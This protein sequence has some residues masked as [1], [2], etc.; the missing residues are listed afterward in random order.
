M[1]KILLFILLLVSYILLSAQEKQHEIDLSFGVAGG[2]SGRLPFWLVSNQYSLLEENSFNI[3]SAIELQKKLNTNKKF[4][5][6]YGAKLINRY[7]LNYQIYPEEIFA[8]I[9]YEP[10]RFQIGR[11]R[12]IFSNEDINLSSGGLLWSGN[13]LPLPAM[14]I[15]IPEYHK[16]PFL[17]NHISIKGGLYHGLF[18][19]NQ[20]V[21]KARLHHKY[22]YLKVRG[23]NSLNFSFGLHHYAQWA[24]ISN[25]PLMGRLPGS[26][27]EYLRIFFASSGGKN[28]HEMEQLNVAGNH[29]GSYNLKIDLDLKPIKMSFYWQ[30]IFEDKSGLELNNLMD[31]MYG[32]LLTLKNQSVIDNILIEILSTT[33]QSGRPDNYNSPSDT[34]TSND[35]YFN[36][37]LY[38]MGWSY[39]DMGIGNPL[40]TSPALSNFKNDVEY[41][42]NNRFKALHAAISG[43]T[44]FMN[45]KIFFTYSH[46]YGT[47]NFPFS[48]VKTQVS[49]L[50]KVILPKL[51]FKT[52]VNIALG[53]DKGNM[54]KNSTGLHLSFN[55]KLFM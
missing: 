32:I 5:F 51:F 55:R 43:K 41:F 42:N 17:K 2:S 36:H 31:G 16:L 15:S 18:D 45:Y 8:S 52:D 49:I 22:L 24:G 46:N 20:F 13:A 19:N 44:D 28:A 30:S 4:D 48:S 50:F 29:L 37:W 33:N 23:S 6:N 27:K 7:S 34:T 26:F 53:I 1:K 25:N 10:F 35:N 3:Y 54:Y 11:I 38:N 14:S 12:E 40:F 21:N 47:Y 9:K 39:H